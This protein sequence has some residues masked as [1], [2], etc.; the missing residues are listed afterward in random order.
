MSNLCAAVFA[1]NRQ[2]LRD[3][4]ATTTAVSRERRARDDE[5]GQ[6]AAA[7]RDD[8]ADDNDAEELERELEAVALDDDETPAPRCKLAPVV[9]LLF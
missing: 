7:L 4:M 2:T 8:Y 1:K 6:P 9:E 3:K 5:Q